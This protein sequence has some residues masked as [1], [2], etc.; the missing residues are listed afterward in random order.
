MDGEEEKRGKRVMRVPVPAGSLVA[1]GGSEP[2]LS[3]RQ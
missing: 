1:T 2:R 3:I